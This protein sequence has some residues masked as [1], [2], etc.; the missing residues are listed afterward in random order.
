M[1]H[2]LEVTGFEFTGDMR[3]EMS[4]A[5]LVITHAG[6]GSILEGLRMGKRIIAVVN[7]AL[8]GNHQKELAE[9]LDRLGYLVETT[10]EHIEKVLPEALSKHFNH[11]PPQQGQALG[12]VLAEEVGLQMEG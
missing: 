12:N 6:S 1:A 3:E 8:M 11:F 10:P 2:V 7:D 5:D 4:G 9:E